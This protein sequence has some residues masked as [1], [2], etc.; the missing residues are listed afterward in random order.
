METFATKVYRTLH[1]GHLHKP[2]AK[3]IESSLPVIFSVIA[4]LVLIYFGTCF[5]TL[6]AKILYCLS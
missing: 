1:A 3:G 4:Y 5:G 6:F 2:P